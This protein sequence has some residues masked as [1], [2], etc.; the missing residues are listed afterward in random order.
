VFKKSLTDAA[1]SMR[2]KAPAEGTAR[3]RPGLL[4]TA[5]RMQVQRT[6]A[7]GIPS[8]HQGVVNDA[9]GRFRKLQKVAADRAATRQA[10]V[11]AAD[12][13]MERFRQAAREK[14]QPTSM[15]SSRRRAAWM[16]AAAQPQARDFAA[17][18]A[19][20]TKVIEERKQ[21][22][23]RA[24]ATYLLAPAPVQ[25]DMEREQVAPR[26]QMA[27]RAQMAGRPQMAQ[28]ERQKTE[29]ELTRDFE[30]HRAWLTA[31]EGKQDSVEAQRHR[32]QMN[33]AL[34]GLSEMG[35]EVKT[36]LLR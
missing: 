14:D 2:G 23:P 31:H 35:V 22:A 3:V 12:A 1:K 4:H 34:A 20:V 7:G 16:E 10:V 8:T 30:L 36:C 26:V 9:L 25:E 18:M 13:R 11:D 6:K 32:L 15:R 33:Q 19:E 28:A 21:I 5:A 24:Q 17:L 29:A 27:A